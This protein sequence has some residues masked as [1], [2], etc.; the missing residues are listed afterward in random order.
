[1]RRL[2]FWLIPLPLLAQAAPQDLPVVKGQELVSVPGPQR[3]SEPL[4]APAVPPGATPLEAQGR[5]V[6][7]RAASLPCAAIPRWP[8]E[9]HDQTLAVAGWKA[10]R[11]EVGPREKL[12][13]RLR[14]LHEAW[15]Q[16][17]V[18]NRW[19]QVEPGMLRSTLGSG[20]PEITYE[21]PKDQVA[22]IFLV[23]DTTEAG[24]DQESFRLQITR[25]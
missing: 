1:M 16:V 7:R 20:N 19:G 14:A 2:A 17:K 11:V 15:F 9:V 21:N 10:Y 8:V 13:A 6:A 25:P 12:H 18:V 3:P 5:L 22:I 4:L 23:V 24:A